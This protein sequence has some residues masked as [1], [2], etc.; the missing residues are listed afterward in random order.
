MKFL[1]IL[2]LQCTVSRPRMTDLHRSRGGCVM[3]NDFLILSWGLALFA[4]VALLSLRLH[5]RKWIGGFGSYSLSQ[6]AINLPDLRIY[7]SIEKRSSVNFSCLRTFSFAK[8]SFFSVKL[9]TSLYHP[10]PLDSKPYKQTN[11]LE[12]YTTV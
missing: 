12:N 11:M 10:I 8:L 6:A 4:L 7:S 3:P 9:Q 1:N 5:S 2:C